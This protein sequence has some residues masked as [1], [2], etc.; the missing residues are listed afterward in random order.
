VLTVLFAR[1]LAG[2]VGQE[3]HTNIQMFSAI[4]GRPAHG[5]AAIVSGIRCALKTLTEDLVATKRDNVE[6]CG[7]VRAYENEMGV[8]ATDVEKNADKAPMAAHKLKVLRNRM[9]V[10][11]KELS[12]CVSPEEYERVCT[13]MHKLEMEDENLR[14]QVCE[15]EKRKQAF[16]EQFTEQMEICQL[17]EGQKAADVQKIREEVVERDGKILALEVVL[18]EKN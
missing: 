15:L 14:G 4:G 1:R 16:E 11:Q 2:A 8:H 5:P 9:A 17:S 7:R 18:R 13:I 3:M 12:D 10:L 6:L